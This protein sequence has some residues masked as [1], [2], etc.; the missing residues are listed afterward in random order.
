MTDCG[1][2]RSEEELEAKRTKSLDYSKAK[3]DLSHFLLHSGAVLASLAGWQAGGLT[4][5]GRRY[6]PYEISVLPCRSAACQA[7]LPYV[8]L[9]L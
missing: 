2:D 7:C 5:E 6:G 1:R 3:R 8:V 9:G 4:V